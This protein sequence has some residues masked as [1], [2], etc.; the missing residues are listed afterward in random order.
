MSNP[1]DDIS[2]IGGFSITNTGAG[3]LNLRADSDASGVGT[4]SFVASAKVNFSGSTGD[5]NFYYNP[6]KKVLLP[7]DFSFK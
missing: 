6:E 2:V 1:F 7:S 5:V 4:I 3:D